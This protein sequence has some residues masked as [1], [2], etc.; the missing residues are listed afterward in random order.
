[1]PLTEIQ[2]ASL[3]QWFDDN[4]ISLSG[5]LIGKIE[6]YHDLIMSR[7]VLMNLVSRSDLGLIIDNHFLDSLV[8]LRDMPISGKAIDIGSGAGFPGV[9]IAL[10]RPEIEMTLLE[11]LH[12]K[13]LFLKLVKQELGLNNINILEMRLEQYSGDGDYNVALI[14]ALPKREKFLEKI[15]SLIQPN[16]K[17]IVYQKRGIYGIFTR[18][19]FI[20]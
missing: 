4:S 6:I 2:K 7:S 10:V 19:N 1:M 3:K 14:R 18:E 13:A 8:P 12:K 16:G 20:S 11:S 9:P 5:D 15:K 17:I